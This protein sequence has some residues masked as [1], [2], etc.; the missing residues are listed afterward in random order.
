MA[1]KKGDLFEIHRDKKRLLLQF[2][3]T[4]K[5]MGS[6]IR[7]FPIRQNQKDIVQQTQEL[8]YVFFPLTTALR[9]KVAIKVGSADC[10]HN[11]DLPKY[12]KTPFQLDSSGKIISWSI[13]EVDTGK[14]LV[15]KKL[16][17]KQTSY[18]PYECWNDTQIIDSA[19]NNW[20][21]DRIDISL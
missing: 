21:P 13:F 3:R 5:D 11:K 7:V 15:T 14:Q 4:D 16:T 19:A 6:L 12:M 10:P 17:K 8:F 18:S 1:F 20:T 9:K 2:I